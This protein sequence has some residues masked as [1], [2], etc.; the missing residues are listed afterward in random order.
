MVDGVFAMGILDQFDGRSIITCLPGSGQAS[1]P[2]QADDHWR[3]ELLE[4]ENPEFDP[5]YLHTVFRGDDAIGMVTSGAYG[6]RVQK[7]LG[8][9]YFRT[10]VV[11]GDE[12]QVEILGRKTRARVTAAL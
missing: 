8:L 2:W 7:A 1:S 12:L 6:H 5:F 9:V 4:F 11:D 3:M 10:P